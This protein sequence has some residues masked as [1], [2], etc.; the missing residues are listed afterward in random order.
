[1][2]GTVK[3]GAGDFTQAVEDA[4][5]RNQQ[6]RQE[7][8]Q[9]A[10]QPT[11]LAQLPAFWTISQ[12]EGLNVK[13]ALRNYLSGYLGGRSTGGY[14]CER[15]SDEWSDAFGTRYAIPCNSATSG[16]LAACMAADIGDGDLVWVSDY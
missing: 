6:E 15:L 12:Q 4:D 2:D 7:D 9:V 5:Q 16:L 13:R 8:Q 3:A 11:K 1:M 14:W 10:R